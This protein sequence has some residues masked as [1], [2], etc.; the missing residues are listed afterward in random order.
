VASSGKA[1]FGASGVAGGATF[2]GEISA[3]TG[4]LTG[5]W[6]SGIGGGTYSGKKM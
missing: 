6:Q 3:D 4:T 1:N 2:Q 5:T